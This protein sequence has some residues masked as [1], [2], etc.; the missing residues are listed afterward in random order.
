MHNQKAGNQNKA[1][2]CNAH[3]RLDLRGSPALPSTLVPPQHHRGHPWPTLAAVQSH[4]SSKAPSAGL[5]WDWTRATLPV[6]SNKSKHHMWGLVGPTHPMTTTPQPMA[7]TLGP[8][9]CHQPWEPLHTHN[10]IKKT[11]NAGPPQSHAVNH[12]KVC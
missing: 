11:I 5:G 8:T 10:P 4:S 7:A 2:A 6:S 3:I 12:F 9:S 1:K